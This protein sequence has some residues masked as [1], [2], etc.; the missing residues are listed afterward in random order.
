MKSVVGSDT[1]KNGLIVLMVQAIMGIGTIFRVGLG[2]GVGLGRQ[3]L[4]AKME[5]LFSILCSSTKHWNQ[6]ILLYIHDPTN[7]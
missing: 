3:E 7:T 4:C 6:K 1:L 2:L 5:S